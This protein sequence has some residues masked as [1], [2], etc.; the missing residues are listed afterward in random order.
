[1]IPNEPND[2]HAG[3]SHEPKPGK[4]RYRPASGET[5]GKPDP[6]DSGGLPGGVIALSL[7]AGLLFAWMGLRSANKDYADLKRLTAAESYAATPAHWLKVGV[8]HDTAGSTEDFYPDVLYEYFVNGES[9]WGWRLSY[10]DLPHAKPF[11]DMRLKPYRVGDTVTVYVSPKD[12][13]EAI[14]EKRNDGLFRPYLK[15]AMGL[16]FA[17]VGLAL[18]SIPIL[19]WLG[20]TKKQS[21][22]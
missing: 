18:L 11:W 17:A 3:Q 15:V 21:P 5:Q 12:K 4:A 2:S 7:G 16:A 14:V 13:K 20:G 9:I 1:M 8:R 19:T 22:P 10:E 6:R